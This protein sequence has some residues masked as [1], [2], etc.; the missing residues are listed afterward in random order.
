MLTMVQDHLSYS[1]LLLTD[2][3]P[4]RVVAT[5]LGPSIDNMSPRSSSA[6]SDRHRSIDL[7]WSLPSQGKSGRQDA[8][9]R[10]HSWPLPSLAEHAVPVG[11]TAA[12]HG[13]QLPRPSADSA[14][15]CRDHPLGL[16][17]LQASAAAAAAVDDDDDPPRS[18]DPVQ[19]SPAAADAEP[20]PPKRLHSLPGSL[21][22]LGAFGSFG[23][24]APPTADAPQRCLSLPGTAPRVLGPPTHF[25]PPS[26]PPADSPRNSPAFEEHGCVTVFFSDVCGF[27]TWAHQLHP[28]VVMGTLN[29]LYSRLVWKCVGGGCTGP[30]V[31]WIS[32]APRC[33]GIALCILMLDFRIV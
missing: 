13:S 19:Q 32:A 33:G 22:A 12:G 28:S 4:A 11:E 9:D 30:L 1:R 2:M 7:R 31:F 6:A 3:L 25:M 17:G 23:R 20:S 15:P 5:L 8:A 21:L 27:S 10:R 16:A 24:A 14:K 26:G 18:I 29:D